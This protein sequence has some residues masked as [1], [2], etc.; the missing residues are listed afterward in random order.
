MLFYSYPRKGY[1][2]NTRCG[3]TNQSAARFRSHA[4]ATPTDAEGFRSQDNLESSTYEVFEQDPVKYVNYEEVLRSSPLSP[5]APHCATEWPE[6]LSG[7]G[8]GCRPHRIPWRGHPR[9]AW[10]GFCPVRSQQRSAAGSPQTSQA[11]PLNR[12]GPSL[13]TQS[14]PCGHAEHP[15]VSTQ[16]T[17]YHTTASGSG[18]SASWSLQAVYQ[19]LL[20]KYSHVP[21]PVIMVGVTMH[22]SPPLARAH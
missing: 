5:A 18:R 11:K 4:R 9:L 3:D 6:G 8:Y 21:C 10:R 22:C 20:D 7:F 13:S 19:A 15:H 14:T 1:S 17:P 2:I 12:I 16:S